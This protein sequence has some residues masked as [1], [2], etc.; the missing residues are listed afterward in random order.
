MGVLFESLRNPKNISN[1]SGLMEDS[2]QDHLVI[3]LN[4]PG[5]NS[6]INKTR[7]GSYLSSVHFLYSLKVECT[8]T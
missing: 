2:C 3:T 7:E 6:S 8:L 5:R 1:G 4:Q